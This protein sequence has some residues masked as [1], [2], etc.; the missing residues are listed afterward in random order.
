[1]MHYLIDIQ[2]ASKDAIPIAD[3]TLIEWAT[4]ALTTHR[5]HCE[6]TVRLVDP[7][8]ITHLNT[9][10]R[11]QAKATNVL[12][13]P[14]QVP[15]TVPL[16]YPLLGDVVICPAVLQEESA[17]LDVPLIAHWAHIVIHGILHLLGYD[18]IEEQDTH[19]M[20]TREVALLNQLHFDNP[21]VGYDA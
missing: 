12:A 10:Y 21:Y 18:H 3:S 8:E 14:S 7:E 6:L 20:Q 11:K 5:S 2:H 4:L 16:E 17:T 19:L 1:M 9:T 13:F 15:E